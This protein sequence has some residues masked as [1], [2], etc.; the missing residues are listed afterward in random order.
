M[1]TRAAVLRDAGKPFEI[2]ELDELEDELQ[3][4]AARPRHAMPS[5]AAFRRPDDRNVRMF[6]TLAS[7]TCVTQ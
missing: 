1:K 2:V 5:T 3:A 7:T 6:S 4:A